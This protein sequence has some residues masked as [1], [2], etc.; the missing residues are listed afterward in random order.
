MHY[1][2]TAHVFDIHAKCKK[3]KIFLTIPAKQTTQ[4]KFFYSV[5]FFILAILLQFLVVRTI[6]M[7]H[8]SSDHYILD[9]LI[10]LHITTL[11]R[12]TLFSTSHFV[13]E[14]VICLLY[15][16]C[17]QIS[18]YVNF[19]LFVNNWTLFTEQW[20]LD[21]ILTSNVQILFNHHKCIS[22]P[23][24]TCTLK[25]KIK[26]FN[27]LKLCLGP[28]KGQCPPSIHSPIRTTLLPPTCQQ[29]NLIVVIHVWKTCNT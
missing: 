29:C 18:V 16:I 28:F 4:L 6:R 7:P 10:I 19:T 5:G 24:D 23:F 17:K 15:I 13:N 22:K 25:I 8:K 11:D 20:F 21:C 26:N 27:E 12:L 2:W 14:M 9:L 3:I 1:V